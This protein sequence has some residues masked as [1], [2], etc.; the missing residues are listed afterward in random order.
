MIIFLIIGSR[1]YEPDEELNNLWITHIILRKLKLRKSQ[2]FTM[3]TIFFYKTRIVW[4]IYLHSV[5][6]D[7]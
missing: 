6:N 4:N 2:Y 3:P 1:K 5:R 7:I